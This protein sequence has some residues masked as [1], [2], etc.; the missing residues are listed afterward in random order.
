M[1]KFLATEGPVRPLLN[2]EL[3]MMYHNVVHKRGNK[4]SDH[5]KMTQYAYLR[6][7]GESDELGEAVQKFAASSRYR[8]IKTNDQKFARNNVIDEL[9]DV[10]YYIKMLQ[11]A[12]V[13]TDDELDVHALAKFT[14]PYQPGRVVK[15][16]NQIARASQAL[17]TSLFSNM[18]L[19]LNPIQTDLSDETIAE[20]HAATRLY[21]PTALA[22]VTAIVES[23][24]LTG[25]SI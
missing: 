5:H 25:E 21:S 22:T 10:L 4:F 11:T 12:M 7:R 9:V 20:L 16:R 19:G 23:S 18:A 2:A 6:L 13:I 14:R 8:E 3:Y 24:S 15:L 17:P 1:F